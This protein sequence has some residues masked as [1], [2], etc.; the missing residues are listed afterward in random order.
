M[1]LKIFFASLL[2]LVI[3]VLVC[4]L[5]I[6]SFAKE[7]STEEALLGIWQFQN[8][9]Y[10]GKEMELPNPDLVLQFE[11]RG[12]GTDRL[13]WFRRKESGICDRRAQFSYDG[14]M[15]DQKIDWV[16][17]ENTIGCGQDTD[18]QIG[19]ETSTKL[20]LRDGQL[21]LYLQLNGKDFIYVMKKL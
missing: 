17:P 21:H 2:F 10:Q 16:N 5:G 4:G 12:D 3:T 6:A 13:T 18:M 14:E 11:F 7:P 9:I 19:N 20:K 8:I 1:K 15:L